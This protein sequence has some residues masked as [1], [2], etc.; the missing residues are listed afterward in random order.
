MEK[1]KEFAL[2]ALLGLAAEVRDTLVVCAIAAPIL[3][4]LLAF[5]ALQSCHS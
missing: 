3:T 2:T 4:L 5:L 1:I